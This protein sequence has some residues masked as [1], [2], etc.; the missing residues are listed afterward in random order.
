MRRMQSSVILNIGRH[1]MHDEPKQHTNAK[2]RLNER[3]K[4]ASARNSVSKKRLHGA[5]PERS[6]TKESK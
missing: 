6:N 2:R 5:Q 1:T 4:N 3:R